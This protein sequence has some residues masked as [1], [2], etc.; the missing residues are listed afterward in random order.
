MFRGRPVAAET[1]TQP[2]TPRYVVPRPVGT[3]SV[4][5]SSPLN[6][7]SRCARPTWRNSKPSKNDLVP[8]IRS[9]RSGKP[10]TSQFAF[11]STTLCTRSCRVLAVIRVS[12]LA[13]PWLAGGL[14]GY[15]RHGVLTHQWSG[16]TY[17]FTPPIIPFSPSTQ[18][19]L[20]IKIVSDKAT[21]VTRAGTI[22]TT[23]T[24][25]YTH[26]CSKMCAVLGVRFCRR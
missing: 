20:F 12:R 14:P 4:G 22:V 24:W 16:A 21:T 17:L 8:R 18:T 2:V 7:P 11:A 10:R 3:T 26:S 1:L 13:F 9:E 5:V 25:N 6:R 23:G 15:S 19:W